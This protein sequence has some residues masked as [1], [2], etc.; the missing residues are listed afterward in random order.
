MKDPLQELT[1]G[2]DERA[3]RAIP[4]IVELGS[5]ALPAL[6]ELTRSENADTRWWAIRALAAAPQTQTSDLLLH[7]SDSNAEIRAAA[8]LALSHHPG[9]EA[10]TALTQAL[11]DSDPLTAGLAANALVK[12]GDAAV[13][14][15]IEAA[16][17]GR[18]AV[19]IL[20][21]KALAELRDHR[22]IPVMMKCIQEN[23]AALGYWA[24]LGLERLGL[25]MVYI[26]P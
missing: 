6:R 22:A 24:Q 25:D 1:S 17:E 7:L 16:K 18:Q 2:D 20:A 23:S 26:K 10:L 15:L 21:L 9:E 14:D 4:T 12:L 5:A 8:A 13:P 11:G 3:E 19:R